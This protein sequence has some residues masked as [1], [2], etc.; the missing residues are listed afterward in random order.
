MMPSSPSSTG[1]PDIAALALYL[2]SG[3]NKTLS[4]QVFEAEPAAAL[5]TIPRAAA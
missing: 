4:G 5:P 1:E 3:R 2:A